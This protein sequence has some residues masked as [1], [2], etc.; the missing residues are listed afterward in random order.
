MIVLQKKLD[1]AY[2][3]NLG[4]KEIDNEIKAAQKARQKCKHIADSL[5]LEYRTQLAMAKE[6]AG[7]LKAAVFF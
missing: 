3:P 5:I 1:I 6:E 2:N 4:S 7:E